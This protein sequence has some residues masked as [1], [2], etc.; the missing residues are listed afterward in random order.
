MRLRMVYGSMIGTL[1][2]SIG[3]IGQGEVFLRATTAMI[4]IKLMKTRVKVSHFC[5]NKV[6][7]FYTHF[8]FMVRSAFPRTSHGVF[9][10][11]KP[12]SDIKLQPCTALKTSQALMVDYAGPVASSYSANVSLNYNMN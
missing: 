4:V 8:Y 5:E 11:T 6:N 3:G 12:Y 9:M 2:P 10:S 7:L 1:A